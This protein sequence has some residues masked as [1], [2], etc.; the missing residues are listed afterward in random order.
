MLAKPGS[1]LPQGEGW[2]F[3][4]KWDG[5]RT[6]VF[7]DGDEI[8][9]GSRNEKP[10]TRYF[11]ELVVALADALPPRCVV[12]GEIVM[13]GA[14]RR[15]DFDGLQHRIHPAASRVKML[16]VDTPTSFVAFDLLALDDRDLRDE[17]FEFRRSLL[18]ESIGTHPFV[19][20]TPATTDRAVAERWFVEFE[21]AGCDGLIAKRPD[22]KYVSDKRVMVKVKP[23][24]TADCIVAGFRWHKNGPVVGSLLLGLFGDDGQLHHVGITASFTDKRRRELVEELAPFREAARDNHP[25][26]GWLEY[27][28]EFEERGQRVPGGQSR[29]NAKKNLSFEPLRCELVC[30]VGYD[31]LQGNRFRH[32]TTFKRWRPDRDVASCRYDQLVGAVSSTIDDVLGR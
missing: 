28:S 12:D 18:V 6:I 1:G 17:P 10:M 11:P 13:V 20:V 4:P 9:L 30:E 19:S 7:R 24:R 8:E 27:A 23:E 22:Q 25:W 32:A 29:W 26:H 14:D 21:G 5:F 31:H 2:I 16:S 3:E 15:L